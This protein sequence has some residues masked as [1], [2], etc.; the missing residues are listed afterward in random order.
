MWIIGPVILFLIERI[1][2]L[3]RIKSLDHGSTSIKDVNLLPSR[4]FFISKRSQL[5]LSFHTFFSDSTC[6]NASI[7]F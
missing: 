4:G 2:S 6:Y 3:L 7:E 1:S 5:I